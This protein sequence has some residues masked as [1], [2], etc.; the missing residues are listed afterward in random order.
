MHV[1][2]LA[3]FGEFL[4]QFDV[5]AGKLGAVGGAG[6][7]VQGADEVDHQA[8]AGAQALERLRVVHV[9]Y[10]DFDRG[11]QL[12]IARILQAA[13]GHDDAP[14]FGDEP[15]EQV[16]ADESGAAEDEGGAFGRGGHGRFSLIEVHPLS[17]T[18]A[19]APAALP[20][21][22]RGR[23]NSVMSLPLPPFRIAE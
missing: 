16:A 3:G 6:A 7:R 13:R 14:A 20:S 10:D 21:P 15:V 18:G 23:R 8:L 1:L 17:S 19:G 22:G 9:G 11:Q 12:E 5:D 2:C 4:W